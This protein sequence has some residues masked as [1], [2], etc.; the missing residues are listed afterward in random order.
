M[1]LQGTVGARWSEVE[2]F[3]EEWH[4]FMRSQW[5]WDSP[6]GVKTWFLVGAYRDRPIS[7]DGGGQ[8]LLL[9]VLTHV[10]TTWK[11]LAARCGGINH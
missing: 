11:A 2:K 9:H 1:S 8:T 10:S 5:R 3:M 6:R 7:Q 4:Q